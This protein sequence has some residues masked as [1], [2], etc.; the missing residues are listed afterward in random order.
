LELEAARVLLFLVMD[1]KDQMEVI[2]FLILQ[3]LAHPQAVLFLVA[4]AAAGVMEQVIGTVYLVALV[5]AEVAQVALLQM[6]DLE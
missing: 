1:Q 2:P 5:V 4:E 6:V 3:V